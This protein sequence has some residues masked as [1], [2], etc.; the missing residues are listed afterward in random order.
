MSLAKGK[1]FRGFAGDQD[2]KT[3]AFFGFIVIDIISAVNNKEARGILFRGYTTEQSA[4]SRAFN[5]YLIVTAPPP[6]L[7]RDARGRAFRGYTD[8]QYDKKR[9]YAGWARYAFFE[10]TLS[11]VLAG[12]SSETITLTRE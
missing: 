7:D 8:F 10:K 3:R 1:A 9:A 2:A 4:K 11:G 5:G 12:G 6:A